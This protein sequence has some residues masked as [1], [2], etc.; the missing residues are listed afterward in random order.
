MRLDADIEFTE[1]PRNGIPKALLKTKRSLPRRM[2][3][4][5]IITVSRYSSCS[6]LALVNCYWYSLLAW[7]F[8]GQ[9]GWRRQMSSRRHCWLY[10]TPASGVS[11][12]WLNLSRYSAGVMPWICFKCLSNT[13]SYF[14][15]SRHSIA[16]PEVIGYRLSFAF[17]S[18]A[19]LPP[20]RM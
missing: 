15:H 18:L 11:E 10:A 5:N 17:H 12:G 2:L 8:W 7:L 16:L 14:T 19:F 3:T 13:W 4:Q 1:I 6:I 9:S 20:V